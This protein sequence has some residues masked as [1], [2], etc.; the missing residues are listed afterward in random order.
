MKTNSTFSERVRSLRESLN[1][2]QAE[3]AKSVDTSQTTL[4]SYENIDKTPSFDIVKRIAEKYEVSIDW[5]CGLSDNKKNNPEISTYS[6][7][8]KLF[9]DLCSVKYEPDAFFG[10]KNIV[11]LSIVSSS[12]NVHFIIH[13]DDNFNTF[14]KEWLKMYKLFT[15]K[16]I[17]E[18][19]YT[20]W[21]KKELSKYQRPL[22]G[23]PF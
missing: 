16:T 6:D 9:I 19:L 23:M 22:N 13:N 3:F 20:L 4:S 17:D 12:D 21:L 15:E 8:F 5:L 14:F 7:M 11:E 1:M 18:E 10:P 2:S